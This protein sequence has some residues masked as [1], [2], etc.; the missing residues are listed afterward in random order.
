MLIILSNEPLATRLHMLGWHVGNILSYRVAYASS[1]FEAAILIR[2]ARIVELQETALQLIDIGASLWEA[3][4]RHVANLCCRVSQGQILCSVRDWAH[5]LAPLVHCY[6]MYTH[7][8][9][10]CLSSWISE[11]LAIVEDSLTSELNVLD[12]FLA[13]LVS[14]ACCHIKLSL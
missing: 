2:Q 4:L 12:C 5:L 13:A 9:V 1:T 8:S 6:Q 14:F 7:I 11:I 10:L 3:N